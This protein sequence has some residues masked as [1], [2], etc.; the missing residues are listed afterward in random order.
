MSPRKSLGQILKEME[1]IT[2]SQLQH[3]ISIQRQ[4]G[5]A[6]GKI[7]IQLEYATEEEILLALG[8]QVGMEIID[9][10]EIEQEIE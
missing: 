10:S 4:K 7:L 2:A 9:L 3:A 8:A 5:G 6:I 1:V